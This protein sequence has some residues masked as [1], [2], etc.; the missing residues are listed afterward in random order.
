MKTY[1]L[2]VQRYKAAS[3]SHGLVNIKFDATV[4]PRTTPEGQEPA[5]V[6]SMSEAD[7]RSLMLLIK[8]Q[9]SEF[10]KRKARSQR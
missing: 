8:A 3:S 4:V 10:D 7:A 1:T 2:E 5:H 9:L 6:L